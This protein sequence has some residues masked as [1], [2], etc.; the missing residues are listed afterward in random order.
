MSDHEKGLSSYFTVQ[1]C[2]WAENRSRKA[3]KKAGK[4]TGELSG[5]EFSKITAS[6]CSEDDVR[7]VAAEDP[8]ANLQYLAAQSS[9]VGQPSQVGVFGKGE[10][11]KGG[12]GAKAAPE[13]QAE[14]LCGRGVSKRRRV[15]CELNDALLKKIRPPNNLS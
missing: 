13:R 10:Q 5:E 8:P 2:T 4:R 7:L 12:S 1:Y 6:Y 3:G 9:S 14:A 11:E 15:Q